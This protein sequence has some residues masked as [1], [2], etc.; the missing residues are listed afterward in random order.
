MTE[1]MWL[2]VF[3]LLK[4]AVVLGAVCLVLWMVDR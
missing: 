1:Q 3:D 4:V 2:E